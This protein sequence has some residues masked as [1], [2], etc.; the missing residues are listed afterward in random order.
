MRFASPGAGRT[1]LGN[2]DAAFCI[3][4]QPHLARRSLRKLPRV[5]FERSLYRLALAGKAEILRRIRQPVQMQLNQRVA[6]RPRA[7]SR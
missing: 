5:L 2:L 1:S 7:W 4:Q 3:E 6:R